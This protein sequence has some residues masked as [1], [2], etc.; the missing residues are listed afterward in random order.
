VSFSLFN[1]TF[2]N[3]VGYDHIAEL[4]FTDYSQIQSQNLLKELTK[5]MKDP[6]WT[7]DIRGMIQTGISQI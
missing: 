2:I 5:P 4:G 3:Y 6:D 7:T 1:A